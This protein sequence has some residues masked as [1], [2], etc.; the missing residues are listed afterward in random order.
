M[1]CGESAVDNPTEIDSQA[2][3]QERAVSKV[4]K[5]FKKAEFQE[6]RQSMSVDQAIKLFNSVAK[7]ISKKPAESAV[8]SKMDKACFICCNTYNKAELSLGVGPM[9][10]AITVASNHKDRG[11]QVYFIH[12]PKPQEFL[13][14]LPLFLQRTKK[15]LTVFYTGH[16][17]NVQ[18]KNGDESDG[19]DEAMIFDEGYIVDDQL[20]QILNDN[21]NGKTR[22]LLLTDC[23][24]SGS[25]WDIQSAQKHNL[26]LPPNI[27]SLSAAK[28]SQ[29]AKQTTI[30]K[31]SQGIFTYYF[32]ETVNEK[33]NS[34]PTQIANAINPKLSKFNQLLVVSATSSAM[35][36]KPLFA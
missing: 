30:G 3:I 28:D 12:N 27:I 11:Y 22:I 13:D 2:E 1:G 7:D 20:V 6:A 5:N 14:L 32:W 18:D 15:E 16:G 4:K 21:A 36:N 34:T 24:H 8:P 23:C 19:F 31:K 10:D 25:I 26:K 33:K 9:N 17:A 29:T 35:Q